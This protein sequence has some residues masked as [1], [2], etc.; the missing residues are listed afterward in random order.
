MLFVAA[1]PAGSRVGGLGFAGPRVATGNNSAQGSPRR[2]A[3]A[4]MGASFSLDLRVLCAYLL[5]SSAHRNCLALRA[6]P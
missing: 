4:L 5:P 1:N 2:R 3:E 6:G